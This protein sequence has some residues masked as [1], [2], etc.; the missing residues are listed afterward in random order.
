MFNV[1]LLGLASLFTDIS[2]E[3]IYPLVP[4][5]L[6]N[7]LHVNT[8]VLGF[9]EG[10]AESLA[11]LLRVFFGYFSD[12]LR[13]RK[14]FALIGY[15]TS[16]IGKFLLYI[17]TS[18]LGVFVA[19]FV[20]R[21]GKGVR[22]APRDALIA[23][24]VEP[25]DRG[26]FFGL[27]RTMDTIG[28]S[29]GVLIVFLLLKFSTVE[30]RTIFL[31]SIFPA[32]LSIVFLLRVKEKRYIAFGLNHKVSFFK[33]FKYL[34]KRLKA[35][36]LIAFIFTL[37]NSSNQFLILRAKSA[38]FSVVDVV[39][40]YLCY[41][42]SY[43][44][45]SYPTGLLSDKLGRKAFLVA[46]YFIYA[47]VYFCF[48]LNRSLNNFWW[49]FIFYGLYIGF[50]EAIEK[51]FISDTAPKEFRASFIGLHAT[52]VGVALFPASLIAGLLWNWFGYQAAFYF[53]GAMGILASV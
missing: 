24:S 11:S 4:L 46:G 15:S 39:L 13:Q 9:I 31:W 37:G 23:D 19:R 12:R 33:E 20:D 29:V 36:L 1:I 38:G 25:K 7:V 45:S 51:A 3:M 48:G 5:Y 34:D 44:L 52:I 2:S 14:V 43:G 8:A 35:F 32:L 49:L 16:P 53:G 21:F 30:Y 40:L 18:W 50:T 47:V 10:I 6:V 17:S 42:I 41:N 27:H 28:A 26:K 22:G